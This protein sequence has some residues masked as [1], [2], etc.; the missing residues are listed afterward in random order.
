MLLVGCH[1]FCLNASSTYY[2]SYLLEQVETDG[3]YKV[4]IFNIPTKH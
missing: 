2:C 1:C 3:N 4:F